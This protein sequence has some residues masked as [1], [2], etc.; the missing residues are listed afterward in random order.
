VEA[1]DKA[2]AAEAKQQEEV[3]YLSIQLSIITSDTAAP[4]AVVALFLCALIPV[5]PSLAGASTST[6]LP[7]TPASCLPFHSWCCLQPIHVTFACDCATSWQKDQWQQFKVAV[8]CIKEGGNR[9]NFTRRFCSAAGEG[10]D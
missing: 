2:R 8:C 7:T 6:F 3:A 4:I 1:Q 9:R 10:F 5:Y